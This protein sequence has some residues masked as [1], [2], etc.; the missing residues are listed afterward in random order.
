LFSI[1]WSLCQKEKKKN[2]K[3]LELNEKRQSVVTNTKMKE[4]L[5]SL[6]KVLIL[7]I[8]FLQCWKVEPRALCMLGNLSVTELHPDP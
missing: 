5:E 6:D 4:I 3:D 2:K 8:Y 1:K 7:F